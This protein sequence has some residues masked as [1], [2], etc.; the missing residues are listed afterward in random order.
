MP[1][2]FTL[3]NLLFRTMTSDIDPD[4]QV[5]ASEAPL[6]SVT[7]P[8]PVSPAPNLMP[9]K[10]A[11]STVLPMIAT[12]VIEN[13]ELKIGLSRSSLY[14]SEAASIAPV[15]LGAAFL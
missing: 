7:V 6:V 9:A 12:P 2:A 8:E 10:R 1:L 14:I 3:V 5:I 13:A 15:P 4:A 11:C